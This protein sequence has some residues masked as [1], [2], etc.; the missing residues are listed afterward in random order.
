MLFRM[1]SAR[2]TFTRR[3]GFSGIVLAIFLFAHVLFL[4]FLDRTPRQMEFLGQILDRRRATAAPHQE[5]KAFGVKGVVGQP[6]QP[7]PFHLAT[8][9][10]GDPPHGEFQVEVMLATGQI[11]DQAKLLIVEAP[12][13]PATNAA[14][15][16]F[17]RRRNANT[18]T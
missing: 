14:A 9:P 10:A 12:V 17:W 1:Q 3:N 11:A 18:R 5:R 13:P 4:Q 15:R 8:T 2:W 6:G 16:F 7:L